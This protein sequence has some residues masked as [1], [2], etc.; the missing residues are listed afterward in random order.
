MFVAAIKMGRPKKMSVFLGENYRWKKEVSNYTN[1]IIWQVTNNT[2]RLTEKKD[3][4]DQ[5]AVSCNGNDIAKQFMPLSVSRKSGNEIDPRC[6]E[7][8]P[9]E[10][11]GASSRGAFYE[12]PPSDEP[13]FYTGRS[14]NVESMTSPVSSPD[15][16]YNGNTDTS[17]IVSPRTP[18]Q[19]VVLLSPSP[20]FQPEDPDPALSWGSCPHCI[21]CCPAQDCAL[22]NPLHYTSTGQ[23]TDAND[24]NSI[25][26]PLD[27]TIKP[28]SYVQPN[29]T[30]ADEYEIL[31]LTTGQGATYNWSGKDNSDKDTMV[32]TCTKGVTRNE[33]YP[34]TEAHRI[35]D[36]RIFVAKPDK[37]GDIKHGDSRPKGNDYTFSVN[38]QATP[39]LQ[40]ISIMAS[41]FQRQ[42]EFYPHQKPFHIQYPG[43]RRPVWFHEN[44]QNNNPV[45]VPGP[46]CTKYDLSDSCDNRLPWPQPCDAHMPQTPAVGPTANSSTSN[47]NAF[48]SVNYNSPNPDI[49]TGVKQ[50]TFYWL[51]SND[52]AQ[53]EMVLNSLLIHHLIMIT[54]NSDEIIFTIPYPDGVAI[55]CLWSVDGVYYFHSPECT[56]RCHS[57]LMEWHRSASQIC[58]LAHQKYS[59]VALECTVRVALE[60]LMECALRSGIRV[61]FE[62]GNG[63]CHRSGIGV[64]RK[65]TN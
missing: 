38:E 51:I 15:M 41:R 36:M 4:T 2:S 64:H 37:E 6:M 16:S 8:D 45:S 5:L 21:C 25:P 20:G 57:D 48:I 13:R 54:C 46:E 10:T 23:P 27:L 29:N 40:E 34:E 22:D 62:S 61:Y 17:P 55:E 18:Q 47:H 30:S 7:A 26:S 56:L 39:K 44:I 42:E 35:I 60:R 53:K 28:Q 9:C 49:C 50:C 43:M 65:Y 59:R 3:P 32:G 63:V 58:K 12:P 19:N 14:P 24:L 11:G 1:N 31:D 52:I 33:G